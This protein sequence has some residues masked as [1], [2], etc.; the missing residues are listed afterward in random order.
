MFCIM[1]E[2]MFERDKPIT[3]LA[4]SEN[5]NLA[6]AYRDKHAYVINPAGKLLN[7][8]E[9]ENW[10]VGAS[11]SNGKFGFVNLDGYAYITD[12]NGNLIKKI[13]VGEDYNRAIV[14]RPNG[15]LACG[16]SCAFFDFNG[17]EVWK[18]QATAIFDGTVLFEEWKLIPYRVLSSPA[19]Y[20]EYWYIP[21]YDGR[22]LVIAK[23]S[24]I[25]R[26]KKY[27]WDVRSVGVCGRYLAVISGK[28]L[29]LFSLKDPIN[30][31]ED[32]EIGN[33]IFPSHL[34]FSSDCRYIAVADMWDSELKIFGIN[35]KLA[36]VKKL[37][38]PLSVDW[39]GERIAVGSKDV[40]SSK[41][42]AYKIREIIS[43]FP[44][45]EF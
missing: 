12:E 41:V 45:L 29:Y 32:L 21:D 35:G 28:S 42:Y 38:L 1:K 31:K 18:L 14:L 26:I 9:G 36:M 43:R 17:N 30:P 27:K 13:H 22:K 34:A 6:V 20:G 24:E 3:D 37:P 10:M 7:K 15:F 4:F 44:V 8:V 33:F 19:Y 16:N 11:Y 39:K 23:K 5:G 40:R 25:V 2:Y